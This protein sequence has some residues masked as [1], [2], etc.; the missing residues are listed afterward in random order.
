MLYL[1]SMGKK[2]KRMTNIQD[3]FKNSNFSQKKRKKE[4]GI[5][6]SIVPIVQ[7]AAIRASAE[8]GASTLVSP[9]APVKIAL[10]I[11]NIF[12]IPGCIIS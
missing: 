5:I 9:I 3:S 1:T 10:T 8:L 6:L 11:V 2:R 4:L 12:F 7:F